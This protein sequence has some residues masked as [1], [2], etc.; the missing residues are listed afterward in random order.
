MKVDRT[1]QFCKVDHGSLREIRF[2]DYDAKKLNVNFSPRKYPLTSGGTLNRV[3]SCGSE[4]CLK[5][6]MIKRKKELELFDEI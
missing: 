3:L 6:A 2:Y 4:E 5:K 1:C